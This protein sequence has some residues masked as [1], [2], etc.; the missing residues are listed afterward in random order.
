VCDP[1]GQ[2]IGVISSF[3]VMRAFCQP[4]MAET[5]ERQI[6]PGLDQRLL[7]ALDDCKKA[8]RKS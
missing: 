3:D 8:I 4:A 5:S 6:A 2:A 7:N 1:T